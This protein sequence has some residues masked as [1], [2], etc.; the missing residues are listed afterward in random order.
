MV[1]NSGQIEI[2]SDNF[3]ISENGAHIGTWDVSSSGLHHEWNE[4]ELA[5][6]LDVTPKGVSIATYGSGVSQKSISWDEIIT[7]VS[8]MSEGL[9]RIL[10]VQGEDGLIVLHINNGVITGITNY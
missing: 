9:T 3:S 7:Y 6:K 4:G 8:G 10:K 1:F 5:H 2:N